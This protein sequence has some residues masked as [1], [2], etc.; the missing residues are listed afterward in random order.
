MWKPFQTGIIILTQSIIQLSKY[1]L[2]KK[3]FDFV[4]SGKF[5]Q[6]CLENLFS[7]VRSKHVIPN[8][9]QFKN[10]LKLIT[11]IQYM[12]K[13]ETFSYEQDDREFFSE[14]L[15]ILEKKTIKLMPKTMTKSH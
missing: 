2:D 5:T 3:G 15:N 13:V 6:D 9:V 11:I 14:F 7:I 12:R 8:A 4:L 1:L 10:D